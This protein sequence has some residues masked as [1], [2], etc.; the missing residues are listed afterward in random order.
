MK[1]T[2]DRYDWKDG[3]MKQRILAMATLLVVLS[4]PVWCAAQVELE[5]VTRADLVDYRRDTHTR[6]I[7]TEPLDS[8]ELV[9]MPE[10]LTGEGAAASDTLSQLVENEPFAADGVEMEVPVIAEVVQLSTA[11]M[12][13]TDM[14]PTDDP[15]LPVP[16]H[17]TPRNVSVTK[18][19]APDH[20]ESLPSAEPMAAETIPA[21]PESREPM[22]PQE[23]ETIQ[24]AVANDE[25][26]VVT[27]TDDSVVVA[28]KG[29]SLVTLVTNGWVDIQE[30]LREV[31]LRG[32][33]GLQM[34]PDI[35]DKVNV[36]LE[37]APL[38]AALNAILEPV[39]LGHEIID[40]MLVVYKQ[41]M[42]TRWLTFDY[43]VTNREGSGKLLVSGQSSGGGGGG[44]GGSG[45]GG[46]GG[47]ENE[48]HITSTAVMVV[49]PEVINALTS[50]IFQGDAEAAG[51]AGD[52]VMAISLSDMAGRSLVINPMAGLIQVTAEW[53][54]VQKATKLLARL[55]ESL[56]RQVAIEVR[57]LEVTLTESHTTGIDWSTITGSDMDASLATTQGLSAPVFNFVVNSNDASGMLEAVSE[58]GAVKVLSSPRITT[59]NNQKAVVRVVN[60]E[61]FFEAVVTPAIITNDGII[62]SVV[63]YSPRIIPVGV[64]LD[65]TP[66]IGESGTIT[67]NVHP[68]I[69][70]I[71]RI[72]SSPNEDTQ[73]VI[74]V[75]ELDTVGTVRD[76][77]TLVIAGL[78]SEGSMSSVKGI[79]FLKDIPLLKYLFS[80][81]ELEK[82]KIE[83][84]MLLTPLI[85]DENRAAD[86]AKDAEKRLLGAM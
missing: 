8:T 41:G 55:E 40:D 79:P 44:R 85:L 25:M 56:R 74:S 72:E 75:R 32:G 58:Q 20:K 86:E 65:V 31:A 69:S 64:I 82:T 78:M 3:T 42:V 34:A 76:G 36:H 57:I 13:P 5:Y 52:D 62:P 14:V 11:N 54:R 10:G 24:V 83:L 29:G 16:R 18:H 61:V 63:E 45:G 60:E 50:L 28:G 26:P 48:S 67:L 66:Q 23:S 19:P 51:T 77:Q 43:P 38:E 6:A 17:K 12:V 35:T 1:R 84:V 27:R 68:T 81:T 22:A 46:G 9:L 59:L 53:N 80:R 30:I 37:N 39:H 2:V 71:M 73:P 15:A 4:L 70:N 21:I 33:Y 47:Q 49:W 7:A